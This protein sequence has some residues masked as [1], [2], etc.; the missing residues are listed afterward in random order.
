[1]TIR[2]E[3]LIRDTKR[4]CV[5]E[6]SEVDR[7]GGTFSAWREYGGGPDGLGA[8]W[9]L[10]EYAV[11]DEGDTWRAVCKACHGEP[12]ARVGF[13][14]LCAECA[15]PA[16]APRERSYFDTTTGLGEWSED[17]GEAYEL[18]CRRQRVEP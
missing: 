12:V 15:H 5:L 18:R 6:V 11:E 10:D 2:I 17:E 4:A 16:P 8:A 14:L 9:T 1:M 7:E 13:D 3:D